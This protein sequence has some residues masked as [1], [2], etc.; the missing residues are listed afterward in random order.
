MTR[1]ISVVIPSLTRPSLER[2]VAS[3]VDQSRAPCEIIVVTNG[4][5]R[6]GRDR[7][8]TLKE[9]ADPVPMHILSL[10]PFSGPS[11]GR[12][13]GAWEAKAP[14]IAFLDD[15]DEFA[16][17][18]LELMETRISEERPDVLYGAKVWRN[19]DG[20]IRRQK[21][22]Q[23]VPRNLWLEVLY[24]QE[25]PGFGGTN[26]VARRESFFDLGGFPVDLPSGEDRAFAMAALVA[27]VRIVYVDE[28]E[29]T[30]HDPDGYRAKARSDKWATNMKLIGIYWGDVSWRSRMRSVWRWLRSF[31][32]RQRRSL[33]LRINRR[34]P[35]P[36]VTGPRS[37]GRA[38]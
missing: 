1:A 26:I 24:R 8:G 3:V 7:G 35:P 5:E 17:R 38:S 2:A 30:C 29:V 11:I 14:Y 37:D 6:L 18:Y 34:E 15:D 19:A 4:P 23:T 10:P 21:R 13:L 16:Q 22:I 33:T 31:A 12:N 28:A 36:I 9:M 32:K 25:N 20:S 27:G